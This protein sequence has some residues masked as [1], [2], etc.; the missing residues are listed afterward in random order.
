[1]EDLSLQLF[2]GALVQSGIETRNGITQLGEPSFRGCC[3][4][5]GARKNNLLMREGVW[6][7]NTYGQEGL[8]ALI[9]RVAPYIQQVVIFGAH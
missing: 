7:F 2:E 3:W 4:I 5:Y 1:M 8:L 9:V 6:H